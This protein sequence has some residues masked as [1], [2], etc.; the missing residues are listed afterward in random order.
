MT[1]NNNDALLHVTPDEGEPK[2]F[3]G[4]YRGKVIE[5]VDP[6]FLARIVASVPAVPA[7]TTFAMPCVPYAGFEVGFYAI[8]PIGANVWIEFEGGDPDYPIWSGCFWAEGELPLGAPPPETKV[9]KTECV[10]MILNDIP[11]AGGFVLECI[12]PAV[13]VPL[14]MTFSSEG[15]EILAPPTSISMV[16][17]EGITLEIPASTIAMTEVDINI[18]S[19]AIT[20][21]AEGAVNVTAGEEASIEATE[22]N[23]TAATAASIEAPAINLAAA[24]A[25]S[26]EAPEINLSGGVASVETLEVNLAAATAVSIEAPATSILSAVEVT[27]DLLIDGQQPLVI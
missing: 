15:I 16:P 27:G 9:F 24:T 22:V 26:L 7:S 8:P 20:V 2:R 5:N 21:E 17:E 23:A 12:P 18:N 14:T 10:T 4:K 1:T 25:V 19:P 6:L 13:D 3:Y 11:E